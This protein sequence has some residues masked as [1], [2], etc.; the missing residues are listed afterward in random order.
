MA[1][2]SIKDVFIDSKGHY[3]F[4]VSLG[5]DRVTGKRIRKKGRKTETGK[6]FET[7]KEAHAEAVRVK[8]DWL[9][10]HGQGYSNYAITFEQFMNQLYVPHYRTEV[11]ENTYE[12][13]HSILKTLTDRF[14]S[15]ELRK[16]TV[17]DIQFFRI[18]LLD[19][20]GA[21][22][23]QSY[24]A[25]AFGTLKKILSFAVSLNY[26][27][28]NPADQVKGISKGTIDVAYWTRSEFEQVISKIYLSDYYEHL[29]FVMLWVYYM[30]GVRVNEGTALFW[31]DVDFE[32]RQLRVHHMLIVKS[33]NEYTRLNHTK[34]ADGKRVVALDTDTLE[35][36]AAWKKRQ[37]EHTKSDF[38]FSYDGKPMIKST[39]GRMVSRYA[40]AAG[41]TEIQTKGLR[42]SHVSFLINELNA[43]VLVVSKRLGHSS[44]DIT[45]K[46]YAHLWHGID[47]D[48]ADEMA[49]IITINSATSK[50][51][52]FN[53]NQAVSPKVSP[54]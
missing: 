23:A 42:H 33:R 28:K 9:Q 46:Y 37:A 14:G 1:K 12:S 50:Q 34:T 17:N 20:E 4:E 48:L 43:S 36:L 32:N 40:K 5:T 54:A 52:S 39:I 30:T 29:C 7:I 45:L 2:T 21:N 26:L 18:W 41:V 22:Y 38:I 16:L 13:R 31:N 6:V 10:K 49:G 15:K 8:N 51:F 44:P 11:T 25:M 53:G 47:T 24:A 35:I 27:D 19:R 3:Y